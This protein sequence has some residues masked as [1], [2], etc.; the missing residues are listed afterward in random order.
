M[1]GNAPGPP[2]VPWRVQEHLLPVPCRLLVMPLALVAS[3][4]VGLR[5]RE[6]RQ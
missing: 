1:P 4:R 5:G 6:G 2:L 3:G